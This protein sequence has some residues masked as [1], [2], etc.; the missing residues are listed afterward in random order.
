MTNNNPVKTTLKYISLIVDSDF[1]S[2][3]KNRQLDLVLN[4]SSHTTVLT[5]KALKIYDEDNVLLV[6][7]KEKRK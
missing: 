1:L 6:N 5:N 2:D 7:L 4:C 3:N